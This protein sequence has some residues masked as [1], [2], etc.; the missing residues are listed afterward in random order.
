MNRIKEIIKV[1]CNDKEFNIKIEGANI[2][3][4]TAIA[5]IIKEIS[6]QRNTELETSLL[7][8]KKILGVEDQDE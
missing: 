8:I 6:K 1:K 2:D 5:E 7:I 3:L 4:Y